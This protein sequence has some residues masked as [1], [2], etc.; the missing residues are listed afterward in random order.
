MHP[1]H[2]IQPRREPAT[3]FEGLNPEAI[4]G[5]VCE[6]LAISKDLYHYL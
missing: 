6:G 3:S 4:V 2:E 1:S 5:R